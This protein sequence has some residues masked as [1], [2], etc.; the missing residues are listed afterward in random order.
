MSSGGVGRFCPSSTAENGNK[1]TTTTTEAML[2]DDAIDFISIGTQCSVPHC[3]QLDFLP[4]T[5]DA[6][7]T[8]TCLEHRQPEAHGCTAPL[9]SQQGRRQHY[10]TPFFPRCPDC[11]QL[12]FVSRENKSSSCNSNNNSR[13]RSCN[14][15]NSNSNS[16]TTTENTAY[17]DRI[18]LDIRS[19]SS[20]GGHDGDPLKALEA[21]R[22]SGCQQNVLEE[23]KRQKCG[24]RRCK[25]PVPFPFQ[26]SDCNAKFCSYHRMP[27]DH[28][29][30]RRQERAKAKQRGHGVAE[31][32]T[33]A[34]A[35]LTTISKQ[36]SLSSG[37]IEKAAACAAAAKSRIV[38]ATATAADKS[39][40]NA[41]SPAVVAH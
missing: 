17:G 20:S 15:S 3:R 9:H 4:F 13:N 19:D 32:A 8:H 41:G 22:A 26:C 25:N 33:A 21:H 2:N 36:V 16:S 10:A 35:F 24:V 34:A 40:L 7:G 27:Q 23:V 18:D 37:R 39:V 6:C 1:D 38:G 30:A 14:N 28:K 11:N 29:C 31:A 5:C 12:V